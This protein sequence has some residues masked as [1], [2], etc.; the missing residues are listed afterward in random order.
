MNNM[1]I[2]M[3]LNQAKSNPNIANNKMAQ[4]YINIIMSGDTQKGQQIAENICKT[5]GKS[6][7]DVLKEAKRFFHF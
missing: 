7:E 4:E 6:K 2:N 3:L 1:L 5:Y